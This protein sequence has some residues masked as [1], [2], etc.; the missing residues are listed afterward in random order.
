M[1]QLKNAPGNFSS[2]SFRATTTSLTLAN[3]QSDNVSL[4]TDCRQQI[5][6]TFNFGASGINSLERINRNTGQNELINSSYNDGGNTL[7][8]LGDND[9]L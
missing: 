9:R 6:M 2:I 5:T 3:G 8:G 4:A 7:S 1:F